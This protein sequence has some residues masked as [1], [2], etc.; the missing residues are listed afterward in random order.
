MT[1]G[2]GL[3]R[4]APAVYDFPNQRVVAHRVEE[5]PVRVSSLRAL[6]AYANVFAIES[7]VDE[8]AAAAET[9]PVAFRLRYLSDPRARAVIELAAQKAGWKP[10]E[11]SDGT[12]GRGIAFARY[13]NG[14]GYFAIVIELGLEPDV[15]VKRAVAAVDVGQTINPDGVANQ[16]EGGIIQA[17]SWTLKEQVR[18]DRQRITSRTWE[19]Y[20]ILTFPEVPAIAVHLINRPDEPPLGA[21]EMTMGP[22]AAAIANALYHAMGVRIRDLPIT[23]EKI[24]ALLA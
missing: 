15:H 21:G 24:V 7:F 1:A 22:T 10:G 23:R 17:I 6:G 18:F 5:R 13:K 14:Y 20:P 16:T 12:S 8:L 4:N 3:A 9:D 2:G 19:E 11:A